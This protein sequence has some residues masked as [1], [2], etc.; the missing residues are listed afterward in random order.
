MNINTVIV[1]LVLF[2]ASAV[3]AHATQHYDNAIKQQQ[4]IIETHHVP[5]FTSC[6]I[7]SGKQDE[8]LKEILTTTGLFAIRVPMSQSSTSSSP[9]NNNDSTKENNHL[10]QNLCQCNPHTMSKI[11]NG[12]SR[13]LADGL[14]TRST[15]ATAT[16]GFTPLALPEHDINQYCG[17]GVYDSLELM[18]DYVSVTAVKETFIPALDR[19]ILQHQHGDSYED[20]QRLGLEYGAGKRQQL[21]LLSTKDD[22]DGDDENNENG[23]YS[24]IASILKDANHLEHF[25]LYSKKNTDDNHTE[26][27]NDDQ[28]QAIDGALDWHTDGGLFLAFIPGQHCHETNDGNDD[29]FRITVP[30]KDKSNRKGIE[31]KAIFPDSATNNNPNEI[32]VAIMLGAGAEHWLNTPK[33][34]ELKATKHAVKMKVGDIR[35]WYGMSK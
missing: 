9:S 24:T 19:I 10:L 21:Q 29:S 15:I 6:E 25:H 31:M 8:K 13:T 27:Q 34:L 20:N 17:S 33:S 30:S 22:D 11:S 1:Q 32:V 23:G 12:D 5:T 3:H 4:E 2:L 14:T 35:A 7:Q 28:A 16:R 26:V 18:R